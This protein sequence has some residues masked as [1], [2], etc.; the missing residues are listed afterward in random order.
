MAMTVSTVMR[1][2][3]SDCPI[4]YGLELFGDRWTLLVLRD[5]LIEKKT[6]FGEFLASAENIASNILADRL[7]R[8]EQ[9][10]LVSHQ[11]DPR[12][13]RR[14]VYVP[15]PTACALIPAIVELAYWGAVH[16]SRTGAPVNFVSAYEHDRTALVAGMFD[17]CSSARQKGD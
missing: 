1:T 3:R 6:R 11:I 14:R 5:L 8:L 9:A 12:D 16:D 10:G 17:A 4:A 2:R 13:R 7:S 15:T